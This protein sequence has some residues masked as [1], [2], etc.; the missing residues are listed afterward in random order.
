MNMHVCIQIHNQIDLVCMLAVRVTRPRRLHFYVYIYIFTYICVYIYVCV[1]HI[2]HIYTSKCVYKYVYQ[3][4]LVR[5]LA[6]HAT[7]VGL[8]CDHLFDRTVMSKWMSFQVYSHIY[9]VFCGKHIHAYI[10]GK[11]IHTYIYVYIYIF[12][13]VCIY[14]HVYVCIYMYVCML[15][16]L[17]LSWVGDE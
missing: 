5:V 13:Y 16:R 17:P 4:N 15:M 9:M 8:G 11:H 12:M 1:Y 3:I 7:T 2:Y 10:L 6:L 14:I